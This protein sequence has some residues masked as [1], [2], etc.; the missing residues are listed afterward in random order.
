MH[1]GR[2]AAHLYGYDNS[3]P[4]VVDFVDCA[5]EGNSVYGLYLVSY[6]AR[7]YWSKPPPPFFPFGPSRFLKYGTMPHPSTRHHATPIHNPHYET[8]RIGMASRFPWFGAPSEATSITTCMRTLTS[9][10]SALAPVRTRSY[11]LYYLLCKASLLIVTFFPSS[12]PSFSC[13]RPTEPVRLCIHG[14]PHS[15]ADSVH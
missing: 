1:L 4:L 7:W 12:F 2:R 3:D 14:W 13:Y 11:Y 5:I 6:G 10:A 15:G 8:I 9:P